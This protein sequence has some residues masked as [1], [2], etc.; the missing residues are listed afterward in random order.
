MRSLRALT[1]KFRE[2]GARLPA[3]TAFFASAAIAITFAVVALV[4]LGVRRLMLR[5]LRLIPTKT[6]DQGE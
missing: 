1:Q 4:F 6:I 2:P 3:V 5:V